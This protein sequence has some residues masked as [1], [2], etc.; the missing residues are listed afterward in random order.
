[1]TENT[2]P[3]GTALLKLI[4]ASIPPKDEILARKL[5]KKHEVLPHIG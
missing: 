2:D 5:D 4:L 1:M 3:K